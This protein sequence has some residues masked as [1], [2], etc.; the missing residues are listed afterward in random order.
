MKKILIIDDEELIR[1][2]IE[3][4]LINAGYTVGTA[5]NGE[6][7]YQMQLTTG[8]DLVITDILMPVKEGIQTIKALRLKW[9]HLP[10]IAISGGGKIRN[11][12]YLDTAKQ[13]GANAVLAKPFTEEDILGVVRACFLN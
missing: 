5:D 2:T 13:V 10:I 12:D 9:P 11:A 1:L 6:Q 7:G 8:Y 3:D 4:V